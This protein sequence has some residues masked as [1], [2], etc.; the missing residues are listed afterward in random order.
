ME[1]ESKI[2]T[3]M[4]KWLRKRPKSF[5]Y[6]HDPSPA[7]IPDIHHI[8]NGHSYWFEVKRSKKHKPKPLQLYQHKKL[9]EAGATIEVVWELSQVKEVLSK[10][11]G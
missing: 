8:E 11:K 5:T 6:K 9:R 10:T 4:L 2:Q 1:L 3:K 7:G